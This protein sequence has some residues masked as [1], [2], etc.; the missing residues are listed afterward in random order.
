MDCHIFQYFLDWSLV[1]VVQS[2]ETR[3]LYHDSIKMKRK[4]GLNTHLQ[5]KTI[6][7]LGK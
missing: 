1:E 3:I 7:K 6:K 2:H 5:F 4:M